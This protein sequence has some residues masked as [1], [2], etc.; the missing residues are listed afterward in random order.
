M[1]NCDWI[2]EQ[3]ALE[4]SHQPI[5][6]RLTRKHMDTFFGSAPKFQPKQR[7]RSAILTASVGASRLILGGTCAYTADENTFSINIKLVAY[8]PPLPAAKRARNWTARVL[9]PNRL[10]GS[11]LYLQALS[12]LHSANSTASGDV[13]PSRWIESVSYLFIDST[14]FLDPAENYLFVVLPLLFY[15]EENPKRRSL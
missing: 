15:L 13:L 1:I 3:C 5:G 8:S 12:F 2:T 4:V 9:T 14:N 11:R 6:H 10:A 7:C